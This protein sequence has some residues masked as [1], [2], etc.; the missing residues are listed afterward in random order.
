MPIR[1][2]IVG[3]GAIVEKMHA[4]ALRILAGTDRVRVVAV[5]DPDIQRRQT[6]G[7]VFPG[8]QA[9]ETLDALPSGVDLAI[10]ASPVAWHARQTIAA[11][12]R[13]MHVL[14]EKPMAV[15]ARECAEMVGAAAKSSRLLAIGHV[16]RFFASAQQLRGIIAAGV[17]G[18]VQSF[19]LV[20]GATY[21][22]QAVSDAYFRREA[23]GGALRD[24]G[25]HVIDLMLWWF[26][27]PSRIEYWDDAMGGVEANARL[28]LTYPGGLVGELRLSRD[29]NLREGY[30]VEFQRGWAAGKPN[31]PLHLEL[32][33]SAEFSLRSAVEER[34]LGGDHGALP[35]VRSHFHQAF[36]RQ[37]LNVTGAIRGEE[38]L[39]VDGE[40]GARSIEMIERCLASRRLID[41]PWM[42]EKE[43]TRA[44]TLS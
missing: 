38:P 19:R 7:R 4:P 42:S 24:V 43:L 35:A 26:G 15:T 17:L 27:E 32:G 31:D 22:W 37:L 10:I 29:W 11:L 20:E 40:A 2:A 30:F 5:V 44:R 12:G 6:V 25:V 33:L 28:A 16:R 13:G 9:F 1:V 18:S 23:G 34:P 21:Q 3:C 14:C 36:V 8:C 41:M 39:R